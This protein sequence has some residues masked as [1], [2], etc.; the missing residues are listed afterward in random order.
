MYLSPFI[1]SGKGLWNGQLTRAKALGKEGE[2]VFLP[3][4]PGSLKMSK[5]TLA[6]LQANAH[7][8]SINES[9]SVRGDKIQQIV[10]NL[11]ERRCMLLEI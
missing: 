1:Y 9:R 7:K 11:G 2:E 10:G 6:L 4:F 5:N 8:W 3:S